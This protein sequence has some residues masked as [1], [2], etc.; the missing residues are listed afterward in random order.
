MTWGK[1]NEAAQEHRLA[2]TGGVISS[3]GIA[4]LRLGGGLGWMMGKSPD[5]KRRYDRDNVLHLNQASRPSWPDHSDRSAGPHSGDA[6]NRIDRVARR[7]CPRG[8]C[9]R[10]AAQGSIS[11]NRGAVR[12]V[13]NDDPP[14]V[15]P[16]AA[17]AEHPPHSRRSRTHAEPSFRVGRVL[18]HEW[19][20][21]IQMR[22]YVA[23]VTARRSLTV[24]EGNQ[25]IEPIESSMSSTGQCGTQ[26]TR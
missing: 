20:Q 19:T 9:P 18:Q 25:P 14:A 1:L 15:T 26:T 8:G 5:C 2:T 3:T 17:S 22:R 16:R 13:Q 24:R 10:Q 21:T 7:S 11:A 6:L 4:S 23:A 12:R